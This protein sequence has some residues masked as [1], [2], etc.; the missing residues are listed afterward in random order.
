MQTVSVVV[1]GKIIHGLL[2]YCR[3][4]TV[5]EMGVQLSIYGPGLL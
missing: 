5:Q 2:L 4:H 1:I 3:R